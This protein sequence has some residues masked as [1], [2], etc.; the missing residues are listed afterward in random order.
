M[1]FSHETDKLRTLGRNLTHENKIMAERVGFE[2]TVRFPA[3]SL[4]RRVLSTAQPPLRGRFLINRNR[5]PRFPA[6]GPLFPRSS[7]TATSLCETRP[8]DQVLA[9]RCKESLQQVN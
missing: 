5:A 4:S 1:R 6:I 2:P 3:R 7:S 8:A 9:P